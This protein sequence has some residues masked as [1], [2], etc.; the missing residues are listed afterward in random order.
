MQNFQKSYLENSTHKSAC[1][2]GG[3]PMS[4]TGTANFAVAYGY[5]SQGNITQRGNQL[6]VFDLGNRMKEATGKA[7]YLYDGL[8]RRT[9]TIGTDGANRMQMYAQD[10]K[11]VYTGATNAPKTKYIYLDR[12]VIAEVGDAGTQYIHTDGLGSPVARTTTSCGLV[13]RT[14]YE[15]YGR[16]AAGA[17]PTIGFTGHVNDNATGLI[18]MEQRYYDPLAA[19]F[20]SIDPVTTDTNTGSSFNRYS[21]A[22]NRPYTNIDP[23]GRSSKIAQLVRLTASGMKSVARLTKEEA[24][25]AR[26]TGQNVIGDSKQIAKQIETAANQTE[27]Q[28]KHKG[29]D[30]P[31]GKTGLPHYQTDGKLGHTF[32]G[33][34]G[35]LIVSGADMLD[36]VANAAEVVD[37]MTYLTSGDNYVGL[38]GK[39]VSWDEFRRQVDD[40]KQ[41][42]EKEKEKEAHKDDNT[43]KKE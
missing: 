38:D 34:A 36:K 18:Y 6:Y 11:L 2:L 40:K 22:D 12:H 1:L 13:S 9:S 4:V 7:T 41:R 32:W 37:P 31:G 15:P 25:I 23:D 3:L 39:T 43:E 35:A 8:G 33:V 42:Q 30:L 28:L 27:G 26:R 21:Y 14:R 16:T 29:H 24:V 17:E 20:L 10:G 5:D 19:R